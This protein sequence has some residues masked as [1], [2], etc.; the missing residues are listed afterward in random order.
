MDTRGPAENG[1]PH[2]A[3]GFLD[4]ILD[5]A[6][7]D[8][9]TLGVSFEVAGADDPI[10]QRDVPQLERSKQAFKS[11]IHGCAFPSREPTACSEKKL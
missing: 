1:Q 2:S 6:I 3:L 5:V 8:V 11:R 9:P 4:V 10:A 7:G